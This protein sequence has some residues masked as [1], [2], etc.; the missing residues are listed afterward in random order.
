MNETVDEHL[1]PP[2]LAVTVPQSGVLDSAFA[3]AGFVS[4]V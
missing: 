1:M 4:V 3:V 2:S